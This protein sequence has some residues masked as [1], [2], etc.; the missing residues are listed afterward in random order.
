M[1]IALIG[2][3]EGLIIMLMESCC[4]AIPSLC[5]GQRELGCGTR[6]REWHQFEMFDFEV[7]A[8][9]TYRNNGSF[10]LGPP[11]KDAVLHIKSIDVYFNRTSI[12]GCGS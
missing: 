10:T 6:G 2:C 9:Y 11:T 4:K 1:S 12:T 7:D 8:D 5:L 3:L